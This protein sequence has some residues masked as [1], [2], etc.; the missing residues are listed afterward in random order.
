MLILVSPATILSRSSA[1]DIGFH[2][3]PLI[4]IGAA[5]RYLLPGMLLILP[6]GV[7]MSPGF[8]SAGHAPSH[9]D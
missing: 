7:S 2:V 9:F 4:R 1:S 3:I 8:Q 5:G 6:M